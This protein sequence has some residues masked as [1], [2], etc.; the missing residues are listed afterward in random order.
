MKKTIAVTMLA[1][2]ALTMAIFASSSSARDNL[3]P[4]GSI[5]FGSV[6]NV[7]ASPSIPCRKAR[8]IIKKAVFGEKHRALGF[9]C[10]SGREGQYGFAVKCHRGDKRVIGTSGV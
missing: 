9:Q 3:R 8:K 6:Y 4:C 2:V 1:V 10:H 5:P 7:T